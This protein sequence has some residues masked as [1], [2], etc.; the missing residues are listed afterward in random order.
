M[1]RCGRLLRCG[2]A[3]LALIASLCRGAETGRGWPLWDGKE[4]VADYAQ[5]VNLPPTKTFDLGRGIAL[6]M[7]LIPAGKF[8]MGTAPPKEPAVT[9]IGAQGIFIAGW[10]GF[11]VLLHLLIK[12]RRGKF[13]F[14]LGWLVGM[15]V[16]C[17]LMV[18]GVARWIWAL[19]E[20]VRYMEAVERQK[21]IFEN[22][23]PPR[24]AVVSAPFYM[25]KFSVTQDQY[26]IVVGINPSQFNSG[27]GSVLPSTGAYPVERIS[28]YNARQYC[29]KLHDYL[30]DTGRG[31]AMFKLPTDEQWEFACKAGT[32]SFFSSGDAPGNLTPEGWFD[33]NSGMRPHPVGQNKPNAFGLYD[34]HGNVRQWCQGYFDQTINLDYRIT[35]GGSFRSS[36]KEC[37][38]S[39]INKNKAA[40]L[41]DDVGFR[42]IMPVE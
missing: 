41:D 8:T 5:R 7:V 35:R 37:R 12:N 18:G 10:V 25:G 31:V 33:Q 9:V 4:A 22:E 38:S 40:S 28:W 13:N 11:A 16:A 17:G 30:K 2:G 32:T 27:K 1:G 6:E 19:D 14:S 26:E 34:M 29:L 42:I 3:S 20:S 23:R 21:L 15:M 36:W 39:A 24:E